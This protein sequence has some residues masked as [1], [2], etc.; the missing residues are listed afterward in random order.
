MGALQIP[1]MMMNSFGEDRPCNSED[2][3]AA[4]H[5]HRHVHHNTPL[6]YGGAVTKTLYRAH[7]NQKFSFV[8]KFVRNFSQFSHM[9]KLQ[10]A[11]VPIA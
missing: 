3:I 4:K 5:T 8:E 11:S 2:M 7:H 10:A 1:D 9:A 6:A